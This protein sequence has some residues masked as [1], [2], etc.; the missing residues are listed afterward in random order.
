MRSTFRVGDVELCKDK[1]E[2]PDTREAWWKSHK[3]GSIFLT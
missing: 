3:Q 2:W 1:K